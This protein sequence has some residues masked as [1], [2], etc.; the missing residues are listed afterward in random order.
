MDVLLPP[1][2]CQSMAELRV[3][4]DA[5]D[6]ELIAL[7]ATRK[8]YIDRAIDL[9]KIEGIPAR[10]VD[11]VADVLDKV[12]ARAS[13]HDLDPDLARTLWTELIEW[14]IRRES[15]VLET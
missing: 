12:S 6:A 14:S 3:Q 7:L 5:I 1:E 10:A 11:R 9:K 4:I 8:G 13:D 2:D 15:K